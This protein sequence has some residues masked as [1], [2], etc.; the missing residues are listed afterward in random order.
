M[1]V[2]GKMAAKGT[3]VMHAAASGQPQPAR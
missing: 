3:E 1:M 2:G